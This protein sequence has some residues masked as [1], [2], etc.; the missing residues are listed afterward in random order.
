[1]KKCYLYNFPTL[2]GNSRVREPSILYLVPDKKNWDSEFIFNNEIKKDGDLYLCSVFTCGYPDF[3]E[4][5]KKAGREKII[6]GGYHPSLCPKDFLPYASRVVVGFG[7]NINEIIKSRKTGIIKGEFRYNHMDRSVFPLNRLREGWFAD[8]FPDQL[9]LSVNS[10]AGCMFSCDHSAS[11]PTKAIYKDQRFLYPLRYFKEELEN[12]K[13]YPWD[14]LCIRDEGFFSH[15]EFKGIIRLLGKTGR[16]LYHYGG[17][18]TPIT[19]DTVRLLKDNNFFYLSFGLNLKNPKKDQLPA[20]VLYL[21]HKYRINVHLTVFAEIKAG[22]KEAEDYFAE[23]LK[24]LR[25]YRPASVEMLLLRDF[26]RTK[27]TGMT[28]DIPREKAYLTDD[29][30]EKHIAGD[31]SDGRGSSSYDKWY[32]KSMTAMQ[33]EYYTG[34]EYSEMRS[35]N[36]GDNLN[37]QFLD[38]QKRLKFTGGA[39]PAGKQTV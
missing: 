11:C 5:S 22:K 33:L 4:F 26:L 34:R 36:C 16:R 14:N 17:M 28:L 2:E 31:L 38:A 18:Y 27:S 37:L 20:E 7:D 25:L 32:T 6:A 30:G 9:T 13:S 39:S 23:I 19:E 24:I 15:P 3:V 21:L 10:S 35:F 1:M 29:A 8:I 12:I